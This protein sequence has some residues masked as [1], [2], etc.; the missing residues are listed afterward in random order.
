MSRGNT[1]TYHGGNIHFRELINTVRDY[2][3]A[4]PQHQ[5]ILLS[6]VVF[7][8]IQS[9]N[10]S[11]RFL[12]EIQHDTCVMWEELN[13]KEAL[14]KISRVFCQCQ[15]TLKHDVGCIAVDEIKIN[16]KLNSAKVSTW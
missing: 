9:L 6:Q 16:E 8:A 11:G 2:Y 4:L 13:P 10:P 1:A 7:D 12:K 5:T 3:V 15:P 14:A